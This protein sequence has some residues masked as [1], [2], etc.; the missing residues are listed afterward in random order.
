MTLATIC[1]VLFGLLAAGV[2]SG[3]AIARLLSV[4]NAGEWQ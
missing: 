3:L 1:L 2:I 4:L